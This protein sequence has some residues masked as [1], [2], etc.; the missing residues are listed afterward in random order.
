MTRALLL[1]GLGT[2][3]KGVWGWVSGDVQ[4]LQMEGF[5]CAEWEESQDH[6]RTAVEHLESTV[7]RSRT[8]CRSNLIAFPL[9]SG[10]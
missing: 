4:Q 8:H 1:R 6:P 10:Q 3:E 9:V 2:S 5:L 7:G